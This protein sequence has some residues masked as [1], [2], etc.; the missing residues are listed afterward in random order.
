MSM[1]ARVRG[2]E[3]FTLP[4]LLTSMVIAMLVAL[5]V[6][7]VLDFT[8]RRA[9]EISGRVEA[10][11]QGRLAMDSIV[12]ELR[13]QVC[14]DLTTSAMTTR[15]GNVTDGNGATFY[16]DF[17]DGS[18]ALP[19][20]HNIAYDPATRRMVVRVYKPNSSGAYPAAGSPSTTRLL[21]P[22]VVSDGSTPVFAYRAGDTVLTPPAGGLTAAT[23]ATVTQIEVTFKALPRGAGAGARNGVVVEDQVY[24]RSADPNAD[25]PTPACS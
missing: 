1:T 17:T 12:R 21:L 2:E 7:G 8:T 14:P 22:N 3:G 5:A 20:L 15:T 4:E 25:N 19:D 9:A 11:Q 16:V 13:S 24:V 10:T 23:L 18:G 6:L